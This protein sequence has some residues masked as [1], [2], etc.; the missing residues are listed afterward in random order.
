VSPGRPEGP[1]P[2][3]RGRRLA[4]LAALCCVALAGAAVLYRVDPAASGKYPI[5]VFHALTG[6]HCP[7][8]GTTRAAHHLLHGDVAGAFGLNALAMLALPVCGYWV[9]RRSLAWAGWDVLP[10]LP[11]R[12]WM[13]WAVLVLVVAFGVLRNLP[14]EPFRWLAP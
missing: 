14:F 6:L 3:R 11:R 8:C 10:E 4:A 7:G 9:V 12:G 1:A 13:G 5:C 2:I